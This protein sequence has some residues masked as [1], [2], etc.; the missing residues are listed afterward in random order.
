MVFNSSQ[1]IYN[2]HIKHLESLGD[3]FFK[4]MKFIFVVF[5]NTRDF[6]ILLSDEQYKKMEEEYLKKNPPSAPYFLF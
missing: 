6:Y 1:P 4:Q 5:L 2:Q 3:G